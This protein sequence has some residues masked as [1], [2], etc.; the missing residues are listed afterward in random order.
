MYPRTATLPA[1]YDE[2]LGAEI[3]MQEGRLGCVRVGAHADLLVVEGNPL[4]DASLLAQDG[5]TLPVIM[6][7]GRFVKRAI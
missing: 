1:R 4:Q 3:L 7:A 5:A 6:K 2:P